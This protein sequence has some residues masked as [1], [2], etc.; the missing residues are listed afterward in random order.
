MIDERF[1]YL[2]VIISFLGGLIYLKA[3]IK[4]EVKPNKVSWLIWSI[5]PFIAFFAQARQGVGVESLGSLISGV[6][7]LLI[8]AA[9]FLNRKAEWKV[10]R[11]DLTCGLLSFLGL[12]LWQ[13]TQV[14]NI[15]IIFCILA[16]FLA[17]VPTLVKCYK[18]PET[19]NGVGFLL[20]CI[21]IGL[22]VLTIKDWNFANYGFT[23]YITFAC[24]LLFSLIQFKLG[25][26]ISSLI[27]GQ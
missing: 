17:G 8:F 1:A 3:V 25:R 26:R 21:G 2:G 7:P 15:A 10:T 13:I 24:F 9:S 6:D 11:F 16:D 22:T 18:E 4:G 14:G 20:G 27:A 19:E 5:A 23:L 12:A